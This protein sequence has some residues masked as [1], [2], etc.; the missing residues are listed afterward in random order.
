VFGTSRLGLDL[1]EITIRRIVEQEAGFFDAFVFFPTLTREIFDE[2]RAWLQPRYFDA[3]PKPI[4]ASRA[5]LSA[6]LIMSS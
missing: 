6:P 1:G 4:F 5:I 3:A 2:N